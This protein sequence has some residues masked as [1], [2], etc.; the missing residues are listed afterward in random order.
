[1][2]IDLAHI[3]V[4]TDRVGIVKE[5]PYNYPH[6]P[7]NPN[8][9]YFFNVLYLGYLGEIQITDGFYNR[10]IVDELFLEIAGEHIETWI[11][12]LIQQ[13]YNMVNPNITDIFSVPLRKFMLSITKKYAD[14]WNVLKPEITRVKLFD[15]IDSKFKT[16]QIKDFARKHNIQL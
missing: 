16:D 14:K 10:A 6:A 4:Y 8:K 7:I 12:K 11:D 3:F 9:T 15:F 1:L 13:G 2:I 5:N